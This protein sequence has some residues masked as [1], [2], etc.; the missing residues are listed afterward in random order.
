MRKTFLPLLLLLTLFLLPNWV[1]AAPNAQAEESVNLMIEGQSISPEVPPVIKN[2]RTLV[3]VRVIA[4]GLGAQV[5]WDQDNR[6]A[7]IILEGNKLILQVDNP[8]ATLNGKQVK[9]DA[10]PVMK[11]Q[12]MLLP[13]RFVG[14]AFGSSIGWDSQQRTVL[15]N[16]AVSLRVNGQEIENPPKF[17]RI[18][19]ELY[20]SAE[21][22]AQQIGWKTSFSAGQFHSAKTID[23]QLMIPVTELEAT[24]GGS[25]TWDK[26]Q[27]HVEIERTSKMNGWTTEEKKVFIETSRQ[28]TP[29]H[30]LLQGPHRLVIDLPQTVLSD[31]LVEELTNLSSLSM[32]DQTDS[33]SSQTEQSSETDAVKSQEIQS[34]TAKESYEADATN[35]Q[36][37]VVGSAVDGT[38]DGEN[39]KNSGTVEEILKAK[40]DQ[41]LI[42]NIRYSQY[43][44]NPPT[45]RVVIELGQKSR[46][47]LVE[48]ENGLEIS[49]S[50]TPKKTGYLIVVDAGHGGHDN[51]AKGV[52]GNVEK[53]FNLA[54][55]NRVV[56][57]L[58]QYREFQVE[59][60]RS[61]DVYLTLQDRV[62]IANESNADLF[63]SIHAN[64]FQPS[65]RGTESFYYHANSEAF[66]RVVHR[67]LLEAAQFPDRGVKTS[68]FYV[69]KNTK[70]PAVLTETGFLTNTIENAQLT[71]PDFREKI[72]QAL[73]AAIREYYLS[74]Q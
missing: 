6:T 57:L 36:S 61:T 43:S 39:L 41:S 34:E 72:A 1:S 42:R 25:V 46:Y 33:S 22:V 2:G 26:E 38:A 64:S 71:N 37:E 52:S 23:S 3:P 30:F 4:E 11:H 9:L 56:Q 14:E 17:Y 60:T 21:Q 53:D 35:V 31:K 18:E 54:V 40:A 13:L 29:N 69:I 48:K 27:N 16:K 7:T 45:V 32:P 47:S 68:G 58:K 8:K 62:D 65:S 44:M 15:V 73:T 28:V 24:I 74:Y 5:G 19:D 10:P 49:F 67:H 55:A 63:L 51:G 66:A 20:A 59:A 50:P 70:M 12:R